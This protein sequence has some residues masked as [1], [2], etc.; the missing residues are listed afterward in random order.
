MNERRQTRTAGPVQCHLWVHG[1]VQGVGFRLFAERAARRLHLH[2]FVRNL[3]D[4]RVEIVV[5]GPKGSLEMFVA[6]V[7][8]G[9]TGA[10]VRDVTAQWEPPAGLR[11]FQIQG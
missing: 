2:G 7:R 9:P 6:E 4:G 1:M 5:E 10:V 11:G 3:P 8:R